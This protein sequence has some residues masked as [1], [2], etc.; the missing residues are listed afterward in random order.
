MCVM[1]QARELDFTL[2]YT[3]VVYYNTLAPPSNSRIGP[4]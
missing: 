2:T 3:I 1:L 4:G